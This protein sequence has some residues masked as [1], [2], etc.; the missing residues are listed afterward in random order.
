MQFIDGI[1]ITNNYTSEADR[2]LMSIID[3]IEYID[4]QTKYFH[5]YI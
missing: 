2:P 1:G 4:G 3:N 5:V